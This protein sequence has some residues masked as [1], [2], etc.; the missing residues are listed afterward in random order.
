LKFFRPLIGPEERLTLS[1]VPQLG[2]V[3]IFDEVIRTIA[4]VAVSAIEG[5]AGM[6]GTFID[7]IK[8]ATTGKK[9]FSAGVEVRKEADGEQFVIDLYI[10]IEYEVKVMDVAAKA[11][12]VVKDKV[13]AIT[14]K[15]VKSV[16]VH[17]ADIKLPESLFVRMSGD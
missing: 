8:Q 7:G 1:E 2:K 15:K 3:E 10:I 16:N 9:D 11:Q 13:E 14:G 12:L 4:G 6:R 17:I 5:I